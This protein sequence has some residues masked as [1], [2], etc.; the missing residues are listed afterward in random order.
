LGAEEAKTLLTELLDA[1]ASEHQTISREHFLRELAASLA[2]RAAIKIN[3]H[4]TPE[5][6]AWLVEELFKCAHPTN[7]PHGRP[8]VL[9]F[10][11][12]QIE[13][14]FKRS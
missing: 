5:K 4:L 9:R 12:S 11:M 3:T 7:C 13:R 8:I 6:M 14:G 2:C 1:L 10:D